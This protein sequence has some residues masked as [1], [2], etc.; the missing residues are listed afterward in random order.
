LF[1]PTFCEAGK[2]NSVLHLLLEQKGKQIFNKISKPR[3][4]RMK[5]AAEIGEKEPFSR[6]KSLRVF[7]DLMHSPF[8]KRKDI[9]QSREM[10]S[11]GKDDLENRIRTWME[12]SSRPEFPEAHELTS[13][14]NRVQSNRDSRSIGEDAEK[15]CLPPFIAE[16]SIAEHSTKPR[17]AAHIYPPEPDPGTRA[18]AFRAVGRIRDG[19]SSPAP[20]PPQP[21]PQQQPH[22][23]ERT[24]SPWGDALAAWAA[25]LL[26]GPQGSR[27]G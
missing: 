16:H 5:G 10:H 21:P 19:V 27:G 22:Q 14:R 24:S 15:H 13:I 2:K 11:D 3:L 23:D 17:S 26:C 18:R 1:L 7:V 9:L 6:R 12:Q 20:P 4:Y 25:P 8:R